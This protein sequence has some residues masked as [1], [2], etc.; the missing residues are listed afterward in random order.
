MSDEGF[1]RRWARRKT[2]IQEGRAVPPAAA[3]E[4]GHMPAP[5]VG[6][7]GAAAAEAVDAPLQ[8]QAAGAVVPERASAPPSPTMED[9]ALLNADSDFSGFV[10]R[11]VDQAVRR[12]ALKKLFADPH[13]NVMDKLDIYIDDYT[14]PSPVSAAMLA[15]LS[16]AK[17]T[18]MGVVGEENEEGAKLAPAGAAPAA[19]EAEAEAEAELQAAPEAPLQKVTEQATEQPPEQETP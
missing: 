9:V 16:H 15:S 3:S 18:F 19:P 2:E 4:P 7:G 11:G 5:A 8:A 17:S 13:F 12:S 6:A 14:K 1:L 10:A